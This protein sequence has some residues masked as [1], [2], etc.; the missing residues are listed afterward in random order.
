MVGQEPQIS[1]R[2]GQS[3]ALP[4]HHGGTE[5]P[6]LGTGDPTRRLH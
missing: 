6:S 3:I 4:V 1:D 5:S 2:F